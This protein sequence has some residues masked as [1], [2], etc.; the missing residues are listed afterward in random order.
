MHAEPKA[1]TG[2]KTRSAVH[3]IVVVIVQAVIIAVLFRTF[4][5]QPFNIPSSSMQQTLLVGDYLF[6]SKLSYGFSKYS[7]PFSP[8]LFS[9]RIWQDTP[10][11]GDIAVF[12]PPWK[13]TDDYIKRVIGL[14]G[15]TVQL[16]EG[17]L[18]INGQAQK[19]Q[20]LGRKTLYEYDEHSGRTFRREVEQFRE[21]MTDTQA[22]YVVSY[23]TVGSR[24]TSAVFQVP[25]GHYFM[26]GDNRDNSQDSRAAP[27]HQRMVP[28]ENFIGRADLIF[29][30]ITGGNRPWQLWKWPT[31]VRWDRLLKGL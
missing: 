9:G 31:E 23:Q 27:P 15:D 24:S 5:F 8:D 13:M 30:S 3:E 14:P 17:V 2:T 18:Y 19:R 29:F 1:S 12:R 11:R 4:L 28:L 21:T 20:P 16:R 10:E 25:A 7:L 26:M 6:V 22:S